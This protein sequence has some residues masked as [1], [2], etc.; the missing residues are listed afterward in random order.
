MEAFTAEHNVTIDEVLY[1]WPSSKFEALYEAYMRRMIA[2]DLS[3]RRGLE[4][5]A[6]WGN[7]NYDDNDKPELRA[8]IMQ[9]INDRFTATLNALYGGGPEEV[10]EKIDEDD[11][12]WQAA[13][14]G[15]EKRQLPQPD[16]G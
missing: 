6:V 9:S 8:N 5:A 1:D 12:F 16:T 13:K 10:E 15:M 3:Q 4:I 2:N 14:R 11:P 7:S